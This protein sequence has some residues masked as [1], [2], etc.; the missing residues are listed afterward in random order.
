MQFY[1]FRDNR[2]QGPYTIDDLYRMHITPETDVWTDG[3]P[4]WL[5]AG[6]VAALTDVLQRLD[7]ENALPSGTADMPAPAAVAAPARARRKSRSR[8]VRNLL[9]FLLA[10]AIIVALLVLTCPSRRDHLTAIVQ[11]TQGLAYNAVVTHNG[12]PTDLQHRWA[13]GAGAELAID[14]ILRVDNYFVCSIGLLTV[15]DAPD[16]GNVVTVGLCGHVFT[17]AD[18]RHSIR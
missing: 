18:V 16:A 1:I 12:S 7:A 2:Q 17:T 14:Q 13:A 3:M 5:P 6:D 15:A 8:R 10:L 11:H 4:D 9:L